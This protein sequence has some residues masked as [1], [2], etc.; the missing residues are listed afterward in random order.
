MKGPLLAGS[1]RNVSRCFVSDGLQLFREFLRTEFS[2][3]NIEF[4]IACEEYKSSD[5]TEFAQNAQ[6]IF[7]DFIAVQAPK[8][9]SVFRSCR[10]TL[11]SFQGITPHFSPLKSN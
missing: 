10:S 7:T 4:W 6:D 5:A 8:E 11:R 3:E 2:D 1:S 9:V